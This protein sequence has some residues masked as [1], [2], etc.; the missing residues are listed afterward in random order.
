MK[1]NTINLSGHLRIM[2]FIILGF[3]SI[4]IATAQKH[5]D[6]IIG[7]WEFEDKSSKMKIYKSNGKYYGK[8]LYGKDIVNTD[9]S[10]KKDIHNPDQKL[11]G[12]DIIG[13]TYIKNLVFDDG[14]WD[15]GDV[16][17]SSTGK[18]WSCY[19]KIIDG[20]LHFTGY[21]GVKLLG[22]TYVYKRRR[23]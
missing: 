17:D 20:D 22:Q 6:D 9:G 19:V 11:R 7:T 23:K 12:Q 21:M 5:P 16:Y 8:L 15:E 1:T 3:P 10:S 14:E 13:S 2:L 18:T 4:S